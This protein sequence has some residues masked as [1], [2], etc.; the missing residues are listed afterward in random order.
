MG[1]LIKD[2]G[3]ELISFDTSNIMSDIFGDVGLSS[4][5]VNPDPLFRITNPNGRMKY[6][7]MGHAPKPDGWGVFVKGPAATDAFSE[8]NGYPLPLGDSPFYDLDHP[9]TNG[10]PLPEARDYVDIAQPD[11]PRAVLFVTGEKAYPTGWYCA[12][13]AWRMRNPARTT[14]PDPD[15][16]GMVGS[17]TEAFQMSGSL[18]MAFYIPPAPKDAY[19]IVFYL[20]N[21]QS[22]SLAALSAPFFEQFVVRVEDFTSDVVEF[23]GPLKTGVAARRQNKTKLEEWGGPGGFHI[24]TERSKFQN[25]AYDV[26]LGYDLVDESGNSVATLSK[27]RHMGENAHKH[28]RFHPEVSTLSDVVKDSVKGW[29]PYVRYRKGSNMGPWRSIKKKGGD[30]VFGLTTWVPVFGPEWRGKSPYDLVKG[31]P[32]SKDSTGIPNP[33]EPMTAVDATVALNSSG[34]VNGKH[35]VKVVLYDGDE[36]SEPSPAT[37]LDITASNQVP[38]IYQPYYTNQLDNPDMIDTNATTSRPRDWVFNRD[39]RTTYAKGKLTLDETD[40]QAARGDLLVTPYGYISMGEMRYNGRVIVEI[41]N[42]VTGKAIDVL[43]EYHVDSY[44]SAGVPNV[45]FIKQSTLGVHRRNGRY[46]LG[47]RTD[48]TRARDSIPLGPTTNLVVIKTIGDGSDANVGVRNYL[49]VRKGHGIFHTVAPDKRK[50]EEY[51]DKVDWWEPEEQSH[52]HGGYC[53]VVNNGEDPTI[54]G[55]TFNMND[56][57]LS[58]PTNTMLT[59][60]S[61]TTRTHEMRFRTGEDITTQQCLYREGNGTQGYALYIVSGALQFRAW[62]GTTNVASGSVTVRKHQKYMASMVRTATGM[63]F[64]LDGV[65]VGTSG[66]ALAAYSSAGSSPS[67]GYNT[68]TYR[69]ASATTFT[70]THPFQGRI[71]ELRVFNVARLP[72]QI[73]NFNGTTIEDADDLTSMA[74][75]LRMDEMEGTTVYDQSGNGSNA[76][77]VGDSRWNSGDFNAGW[78]DASGVIDRINFLDNVL[79]SPWSFTGAAT[80]TVGDFS[81]TRF[82]EY[83]ARVTGTASNL[84]YASRSVSGIGTSFAM[85][86]QKRFVTLPTGGNPTLMQIRD[87]TGVVAEAQLTTGGQLQVR[88]PGAGAWTTF[89]SGVEAG[90]RMYFEVKVEN[91]GTA[92][93]IIRVFQGQFHED[94]LRQ[95]AMITGV[96][97]TS[98]SVTEVRAGVCAVTA[99]ITNTWDFHMGEIIISADGKVKKQYLPGNYI[100]YYGP[101]GTPPN[102]QYGM[103]DLAL[104]VV[105]GATMTHSIYAMCSG[106]LKGEDEILGATFY[107]SN[108]REVDQLDYLVQFSDIESEWKRH[109]QTFTVPTDAAYMKYDRNNIGQGTYRIQGLQVEAGSSATTFTARHSSTGYVRVKFDSI[110]PGCEPGKPLENIGKAVDLLAM[111]FTGF[112]DDNTSITLQIASSATKNGTYSAYFN[113]V[114]SVPENRW[115]ELKATLTTTDLSLT[116]ILKG[117]YLNFKRQFPMLLKANGEEYQGGTLINNMPP[118]VGRRLVEV[119]QMDDGSGG[120]TTWGSEE[121]TSWIEPTEVQVFRDSTLDEISRNIGSGDS[122]FMIEWYGFLYTVRVV[123]P[124]EF[125]S[126][127]ANHIPLSDEDEDFYR[128]I[129]TMPRMEVIAEQDL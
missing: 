10:A 97:L 4:R 96:T 113:N 18:G 45:T 118:P 106:L 43:M 126:R 41:A 100:E 53:K 82:S 128:H 115:Y 79:P 92:N 105:P 65:E 73:S 117:L 71:Y 102:E 48:A 94:E 16:A 12:A 36:P 119:H 112:E 125:E 121:P 55:T 85:G 20:T 62:Q 3:H 44:T 52:P 107:D 11:A 108:D 31:N 39:A 58:I 50:T 19:E 81:A 56:T 69:T 84:R 34:L 13:H 30:N 104:P 122:T 111:G 64:Y 68:G 114:T 123:E 2:K 57:G 25:K 14:T 23:R 1:S 72:I 76:T 24:D 124:I 61:L 90:E 109:T 67:A 54:Q 38:R 98:R 87:G 46:Q 37:V 110:T 51:L 70:Q 8:Q 17:R 116:P 88:G 15:V 63:T 40:G 99:A 9:L 89:L 120:F 32:P 77:L 27:L 35:R 6:L 33:T 80:A 59:G 93:G 95:V 83:G 21:V 22:T 47:F 78:R 28:Y 101:E 91:L 5:N 42:H 74:L 7:K 66:T 60:T 26:Q 103:Y 75:Y 127:R 86:I 29:R 49:T 129:I